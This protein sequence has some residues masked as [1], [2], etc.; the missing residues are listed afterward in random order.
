MDLTVHLPMKTLNYRH[1]RYEL[2]ANIV[3]PRQFR[4]SS[5]RKREVSPPLGGQRH[6]PRDV[7]PF[8]NPMAS[9]LFS[10][11]Y[12]PA[13]PPTDTHPT[14]CPSAFGHRLSEA[15]PCSIQFSGKPC[16]TPQPYRHKG[17]TTIRNV[18]GHAAV[19]GE[20]LHPRG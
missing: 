7:R 9:F 11:H 1:S 2:E 6:I 17:Q 18:Q 4:N 15:I 16:P 8:H 5:V 10:S 14:L 20:N 13:H 12:S 19:P 3:I